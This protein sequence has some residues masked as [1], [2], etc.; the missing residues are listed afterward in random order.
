MPVVAQDA[1]SIESLLA[2]MIDHDSVARFPENNFRLRQTS[3]YNVASKTPDEPKGWF[4]NTDNNKR[5]NAKNFV[6]TEK[7]NG[8]TEWVL[9]DHEGA[10]VMV[11]TWMPWHND[12]KG[13][14]DI[15]MRIYL[16]GA[17]EPTIEG[18]MLSMFEGKDLIPYPFAHTSLRSAVSFFPIP[19]AKRCK[20][21]KHL[22]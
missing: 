13:G 7:V 4:K 8:E 5:P 22:R 21:S 19:Y 1:V 9:M 12:K 3:S 14:S 20:V 2:E 15:T 10:G 16:D 11:R 18:N 17:T 6:R